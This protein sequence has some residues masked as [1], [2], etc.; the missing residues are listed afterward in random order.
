M[1]TS[2]PYKHYYIKKKELEFLH[3]ELGQDLHADTP[4]IPI[5]EI[6]KSVPFLVVIIAQVGKLCFKMH[7][8]PFRIFSIFQV[9]IG[10]S[11]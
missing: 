6:I 1:V 9:M 4:K 3:K 5:L 10:V 8:H 2:D 11:F 7:M